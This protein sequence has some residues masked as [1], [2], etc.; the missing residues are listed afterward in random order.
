VAT[1]AQRCRRHRRTT[2]IQRPEVGEQRFQLGKRC[3]ADG[4]APLRF[5]LLQQ[6]DHSARDGAA[7]LR[8]V[9]A[10]R[11]QIVGRVFATDVGV[12]LEALQE[13]IHRLL[14]DPGAPRKVERAAAVRPGILQHRHMRKAK[15]G[16][17][18]CVEPRDQSALDHLRRHAQERPDQ[19]R[20]GRRRVAARVGIGG[21]GTP[22]G[23][24]GCAGGRS[25]GCAGGLAERSVG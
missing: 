20:N 18:R 2:E 21:A 22:A 3:V 15:L 16:E 17:A 9:N 8:E 25:G 6:L 23:A 10:P 24:G 14:A 5:D 11:A 13:L 19:R 4:A 1:R 12:L 7:A